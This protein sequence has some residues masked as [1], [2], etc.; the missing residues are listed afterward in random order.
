MEL[1]FIW[2]WLAIWLGTIWAGIGIGLIGK[3][4]LEAM[5]RNPEQNYMV[6]AILAIAFAEWT[7]IFA[8][9]IAFMLMWK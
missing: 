9:V 5:S 2:S 1:Q 4:W 6:S 3:A 8:L 7:A